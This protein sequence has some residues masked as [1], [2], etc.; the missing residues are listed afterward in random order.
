MWRPHAMTSTR[1][2]TPIAERQDTDVELTINL[3]PSLSEDDNDAISTVMG[4]LH[5]GYFPPHKEPS[6]ARAKEMQ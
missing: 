5:C 4:G 2:W 1:A 6:S 3:I